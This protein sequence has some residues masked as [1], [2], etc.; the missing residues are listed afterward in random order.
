MTVKAGQQRLKIWSLPAIA[1]LAANDLL[2]S[3]ASGGEPEETAYLAGTLNVT[4]H[5]WRKWTPAL[6]NRR[7]AWV[8]TTGMLTGSDRSA[9]LLVPN[10]NIRIRKDLSLENSEKWDR[11]AVASWRMPDHLLTPQV[12]AEIRSYM[13]WACS[14][15]CSCARQNVTFIDA[16]SLFSLDDRLPYPPKGPRPV[17]DPPS[18]LEIT[19]VPPLA[20]SPNLLSPLNLVGTPK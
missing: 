2:K 13:V 14:F 18:A 8:E 12:M 9:S 15:V 11:E 7:A 16:F 5:L 17:R 6:E 19:P 4:M 1:V 3:M 10:F 20:L